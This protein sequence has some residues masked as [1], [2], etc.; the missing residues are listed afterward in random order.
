MKRK[1]VSIVFTTAMMLSVLQTAVLAA[2]YVPP[3][4]YGVPEDVGVAFNDDIDE[5]GRWSFDIGFAASEACRTLLE[6]QANSR[7]EAAGYDS[8]HVSVQ[9]DYKLDNGQWRSSIA[10]YDDWVFTQDSGFN[11]DT[12]SWTGNCN[13]D[14]DYFDNALAGGI[15]PGGRSYFDSHTMNFRVRFQISFYHSDTGED[16]E[17]Y[18]PWSAEIAYN[19]N[20]KIEDSSALI[21]HAPTLI[22]VELD[23]YETGQP[24][25]IFKA[26]KAH[27]EIQL[28]NSISNQRVF[29]NV[30]VRINGGAWIDTGE[31]L[32]LKEAFTVDANDN[33]GNEDITAAATYE[34]KFR[35]SFD[36]QYY[37]AAGKSGYVY[38]PFSNTIT[39]G[40]PAYEGA[41]GW[42]KVEL[43][44]ASEYGLI[45]DHIK[46]DMSGKIT[47]EEFAEIAVKLYESYTGKT[48]VVGDTSFTDTTNPEILKAAN[49][50]MVQGVGNN[51]YAPTQLVTREEMATILLRALKVIAPEE[52]FT[53]NLN[54]KFSDDVKVET[55][56]RE[57][58]YFCFKTSIVT[59][60]GNN[61]FDP[62]GDA[63]REMAVIVCKRAYEYFNK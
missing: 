29:T 21:N 54:Q 49:L 47:R 17:Y 58:V 61:M 8:L 35:Y 4:S 15:L 20:Q 55:W 60:V 62:D 41:S 16:Y 5:S 57:G 2:D 19:N 7:F 56:A 32:W 22:S 50:G 37:P 53:P 31:Y 52:D 28:L 27:N 43:D 38:S 6:A 1:I 59:G 3:A 9:G 36:N 33:L 18:S 46:G 34:A 42:A 48:A 10:D 23:T 45:T 13:I 40:M 63:T 12:G 30:W 39:H 24:Y 14:D 25:L 51:K 26:D 44:K 11:A